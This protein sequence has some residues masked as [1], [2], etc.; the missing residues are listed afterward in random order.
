[1][2]KLFA[3]REIRAIAIFL[4]LCLILAVIARLIRPLRNAELAT[5]M[6]NE[7]LARGDSIALHPFDPN[8][9]SYEELRAMGIRKSLAVHLVKYRT[10]GKVYRIKE[11]VAL[12]YG[13]TDSIYAVL[14]PYITIGEKYRLAKGRMRDSF[15]RGTA[16]KFEPRGKRKISLE[17]FRIDT[18]GAKFLQSTGVLSK[19]Q[20][21][22]LVRWRDLS[23]IYDMEELR[24]CYVVSD[25]AARLMEPYVIFPEPRR[26]LLE[27]PIELNTADSATLRM[28]RGIGAKTVGRI[29][30]YRERL[31]G[32]ARVEQLRE[33]EGMTEAN[34]ELILKQIS[35]NC[36][37]IRKINLNFAPRDELA[38][39]PYI[40]P[41]ILRRLLKQRQ[42]KGGWS[43]A[44]ELLKD[45]IL[46]K[47]EAE[48]LA[49]Y[50]VFGSEAPT[51][52]K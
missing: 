21:E 10:A 39:H 44:E 25:S 18:V 38:R 23:G 35:C 42:L 2:S 20:A 17:P 4:V 34:Y 1:M 7:E 45:N 30:E 3:D 50:V 41:R 22:A 6:I 31:G 26:D 36:C 32:Y 9:V 51:P 43:T 37:E 52:G 46:T 33:V 28:V 15:A 8:E 13:V 14:K 49:P 19:R 12:C 29:L 40:S 47:E 16:W 48:R 24:A 5:R 27:E 11:D